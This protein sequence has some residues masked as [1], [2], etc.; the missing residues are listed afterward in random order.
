VII[1]WGKIGLDGGTLSNPPV[2]PHRRA[3]IHSLGRA[4]LPIRSPPGGTTL[5]AM[6]ARVARGG[7]SPARPYD[8][9]SSDKAATTVN[10]A[11]R[12][13]HGRA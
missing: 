8:R 6:V 3:P 12:A 11:L 13:R 9:S 4:Q 2:R 10:V 5:K 1:K 7:S